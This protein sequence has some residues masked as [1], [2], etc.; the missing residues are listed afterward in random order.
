M[1]YRANQITRIFYQ[2]G[3][4][5]PLASLGIALG[6]EGLRAAKMIQGQPVEWDKLLAERLTQCLYELGPT[7]IKLGQMMASRPDLVGEVVSEELKVL[8]DGVPALPFYQIEEILFEELGKKKVHGK[9][10]T[11]DPAA[12][13]SGSLGQ[14]H[15]AVL[16]DGRSVIVKVQKR[17]VSHI[18]KTDLALIEA[19]IYPLAKIYPKLS[20]LS[21]FRDFKAATLRELDYREEA[22]N[23]EKFKKNYASL[24]SDPMVSFPSYFPDLTTEKVLV[25]EPMQG[26][27]FSQIKKGSTVARKAATLSLAAILEQIFDHG[28]FHADP[29]AGNL[30][31]L[32]E[33]GK[34]GFIDLGLVGQLEP[35]DKKR[36][37]KVLLALLKRDKAKLAKSL[38]DLGTPGKKTDFKAFDKDIHKLLDEVQKK[39]VDSFR[40][41]ELVNR[42]LEISNK[43]KLYI[44]NRYLMMLRSCL[45][46]EGLARSL[47]PQL[48]LFKIA[49][50]I[51]AKSLLKSYNPL[52]FLRRF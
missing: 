2:Y 50:P 45:V 27:K 1:V 37:L 44:P 35:E 9:F 51:V 19:A 40:I 28:F 36:F 39:G 24:F 7:F 38:F 49:T 16:R 42:L 4:I 17:K 43:H 20:L 15:R 52:R 12:L 3:L 13:A 25:L 22:K 21:I 48:S 14:V 32:E 47:D 11:I 33:E 18:V 31:F 26:Q 41:Q 29:H 23:I 10:K 8:L 5:A 46:V 6:K 34:I 30:F